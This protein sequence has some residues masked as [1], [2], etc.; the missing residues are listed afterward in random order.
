MRKHLHRVQRPSVCGY[1][2]ACTLALSTTTFDGAS[3]ETL[4]ENAVST[5]VGAAQAPKTPQ[6]DEPQSAMDETYEAQPTEDEAQPPDVGPTPNGASRPASAVGER[7]SYPIEAGD[8][9]KILVYDR[10]DLTAEY[11]VNDQ[12][13][14]RI[15][16][17]GTFEAAKRSASQL[18]QSIA[19]ML[20]SVLQRPGIV[21]VEIVERR[22]IF[23][24]GRVAKP[25]AYR[26]TGGMAVIHAT[27]LAGG[28]SAGASSILLPTE[29]LRESA[30]VRT[31]GEELKRLLAIQARLTAERD[32]SSEIKT[33]PLLIQLAGREGAADFIRDEREN[34]IHQRDIQD[35]QL[36]LLRRSIENG[37]TEVAAF[38][39]ELAKI[40]EQ[41][42]I[43]ER[44]VETVDALSKKGLATQ[45]RLTD[46]QFLLASADRDAQS[47]IA[48]IAR[49]QQNLEKAEHDLDGVPLERQLA[50]AKE[51]QEVNKR[52]ATTQLS[53]EGSKKV[54]AHI[55]GIPSELLGE[56]EP[57]FRYEIVRTGSDGE[58]HATEANEMTN[59]QPGDIV[60][61]SL[62][63]QKTYSASEILN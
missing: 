63:E 1:L 6:A 20:E 10:V 44:T 16:T 60:R 26:F 58:L 28:T 47:A 34:M 43:R 51:L 22:P 8:R 19:E 49:S 27:T 56:R 13:K 36:A 46:S 17:L 33:P 48:N 21:T 41:R 11:R 61:I 24:T 50:I 42:T 14:I 53:I 2:L 37:K 15:P 59:L 23:V 54:I 29:A 45:Q 55:T 52:I 9:L 30:L 35:R 40:H 4:S 7:D 38:Q 62:P 39:Q 12:G 32:G 18:E 25:G 3:A 31:G 57:R 5:P